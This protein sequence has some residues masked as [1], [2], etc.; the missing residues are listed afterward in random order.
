MPQ[1]SS[2][3]TATFCLI[4]PCRDEA[5]YLK[6]NIQSV[7]NQTRTPDLWVIVDDGSTDGSAEIL[8]EAKK[9]HPYISIVQKP[10]R[11]QRSIG[12]GVIEAFN[13]GLSTINLTDFDFICKFDVDLLLPVKYFELIIEKM[14]QDPSLGNYSGKV[15]F[16]HPNGDLQSE[17]LGDEVAVGQ[18]KFYRT[19][20][21]KDIGG[22]PPIVG[23]DGIDGH[24]CRMKGWVALAE[25]TEDTRII[26]MRLMGASSLSIWKGRMRWGRG[27]YYMGS[28]WLYLLATT[29]YR[30]FTKPYIIGGI[31]I[32]AGYLS[33]WLHGEK[34]YGDAAFHRYLRTFEHQCLLH[35]KKRTCQKY[36]Q[37]IR[38][39]KHP[40]PRQIRLNFPIH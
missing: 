13:Y 1:A 5:A 35:G 19:Q 16:Q 34:Q 31:G 22:F 27:K 23:W 11:G 4:T 37:I 25:D 7:A 12:P 3:H 26:E 40:N 8:R 9:R 6:Q 30:M 21:F 2:K 18:A 39:Q 17:M 24:L 20:C 14:Q 28:S 10:D 36:N 32:F 38:A 15:F 33:A 29:F